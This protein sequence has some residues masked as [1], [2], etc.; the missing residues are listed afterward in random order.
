MILDKRPNPFTIMNCFPLITLL[1]ATALGVHGQP[2][3]IHTDRPA[4]LALPL[5]DKA[6]S[7]VFVVF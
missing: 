4:P 5:P 7:L 3:Q 2:A 6:E 1:L